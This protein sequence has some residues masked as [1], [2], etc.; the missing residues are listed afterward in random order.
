MC[1]GSPTPPRRTGKPAGSVEDAKYFLAWIDRLW[2][3]RHRQRELLCERI[4][5]MRVEAAHPP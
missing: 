2:D 1:A 5:P 3:E 4:P